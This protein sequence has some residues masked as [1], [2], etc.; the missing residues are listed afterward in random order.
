MVDKALASS[1]AKNMAFSSSSSRVSK[2]ML[3]VLAAGTTAE[4][5]HT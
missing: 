4:Y 2:P 5:V 1:W 3:V